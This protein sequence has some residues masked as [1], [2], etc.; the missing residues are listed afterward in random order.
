MNEQLKQGL[1]VPGYIVALYILTS[2]Y[3][4]HTYNTVALYTHGDAGILICNIALYTRG[5]GSPI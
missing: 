2:N 3:Q 1:H 5:E 4:Y